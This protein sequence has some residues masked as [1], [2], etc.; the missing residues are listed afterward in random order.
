MPVVKLSGLYCKYQLNINQYFEV[1]SAGRKEVVPLVKCFPSK[2]VTQT[3]KKEPLNPY[4][5]GGVSI[6]GYVGPG[7]N[8]SA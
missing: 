8:Q 5:R 6:R 7:A 2:K 4:A 1:L 3:Y